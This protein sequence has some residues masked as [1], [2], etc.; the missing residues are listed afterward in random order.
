M[1]G[2]LNLLLIASVHHQLLE[3]YVGWKKLI[4]RQNAGPCP[5]REP[6]VVQYLSSGPPKL[7]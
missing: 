7:G 3:I 1:T 6:Y 4:G 5:T 2:T